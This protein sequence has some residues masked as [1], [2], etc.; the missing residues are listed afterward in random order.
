MPFT[1]VPIFVIGTRMHDGMSALV[2]NVINFFTCWSVAVRESKQAVDAR[3][4]QILY[5]SETIWS[6]QVT[7]G[8]SEPFSVRSA[9]TEYKPEV[10]GEGED[11]TTTSVR[12]NFNT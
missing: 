1:S 3:P 7:A 10:T 6:R 12:L 4:V 9:R 11:E 2:I 8:F 5:R